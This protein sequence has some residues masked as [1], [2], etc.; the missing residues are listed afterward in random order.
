MKFTVS[1]IGIIL[2]P[3]V[4]INVSS[5]SMYIIIMLF[6]GYLPNAEDQ[7]DRDIKYLRAGA[8]ANTLCHGLG[9]IQLLGRFFH[10]FKLGKGL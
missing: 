8:V 2:L 5:I 7:P 9:C 10:I 1:G 4:R 3:I 6:P